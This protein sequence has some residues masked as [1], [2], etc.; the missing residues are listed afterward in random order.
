MSCFSN[1]FL[2]PEEEANGL[3][4]YTVKQIISIRLHSILSTYLHV[5]FYDTAYLE[6]ISPQ[7]I[8]YCYT[9][10]YRLIFFII[11]LEVD[12]TTCILDVR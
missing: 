5:K 3:V 11:G 10:L 6:C 12:G 7:N 4:Y 9:M 1:M 8:C 2:P